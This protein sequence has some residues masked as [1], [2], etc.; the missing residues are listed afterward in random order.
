[1]NVL[2]GKREFITAVDHESQGSNSMPTLRL[3]RSHMGCE[4]N[5]WL[6]TSK[7]STLRHMACL[8]T[9]LYYGPRRKMNNEQKLYPYV[10]TQQ[11]HQVPLAWPQLGV[12]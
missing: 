11:Y 7:S 12:P 10:A 5:P 3:S 9:P 2:L 6:L 4:C 1:M 8:M